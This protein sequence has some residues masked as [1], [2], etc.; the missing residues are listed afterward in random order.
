M[1][2]I[3]KVGFKLDHE[4]KQSSDKKLIVT[5]SQG[6]EFMGYRVCTHHQIV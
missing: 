1:V 3:E 5:E 2:N 6:H 4:G